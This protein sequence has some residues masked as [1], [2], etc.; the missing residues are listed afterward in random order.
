MENKN[1]WYTVKVLANREKSVAERLKYELSKTESLINVV[2]PTEKVFFSKNGKKAHRERIMYPGYIF[3]E[4]DSLGLL[5]EVLKMIPGNTGVLKGKDGSPSFLRQSEIDK[6]MLDISKPELE[7]DLNN[8]VIGEDVMINS[9]PFDGF[10]GKI[11]ELHKE[12]NKVKLNVL[13]FGR[14][15]P[16]D[17]NMEQIEKIIE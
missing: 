15:T 4:S 17:L 14:S 2:V 3:V 1:K 11:E 6:M 7:I 10:K 16:V 13:I 5:Q 9:G 12:K 8:Y